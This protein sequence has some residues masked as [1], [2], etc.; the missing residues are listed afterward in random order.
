VSVGK[1]II[2]YSH[3]L[4]KKA[5]Q[6]RLFDPDLEVKTIGFRFN[7]TKESIWTALVSWENAARGVDR[8]KRVSN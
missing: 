1:D 8:P 3:N 2:H 6:N 4:V 7:G 5:P